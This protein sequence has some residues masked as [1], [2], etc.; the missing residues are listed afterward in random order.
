LSHGDARF[1]AVLRTGERLEFLEGGLH[2]FIP[3]AF[4]LLS[5]GIGHGL[6]EEARSMEVHIGVQVLPAG[7]VEL[8]GKV[9]GN[10]GL[11]QVFAD[12]YGIFRFRQGIVV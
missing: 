7:G 1:Q 9:L 5:L 4:P 6:G 10:M 3:I 11:A 12:H 2:V 8:L